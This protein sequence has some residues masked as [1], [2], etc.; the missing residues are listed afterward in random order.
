MSRTANWSC[1]LDDSGERGEEMQGGVRGSRGGGG[2]EAKLDYHNHQ[3]TP[4]A[5]GQ[6]TNPERWRL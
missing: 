2:H 1:H 3:L 4:D 5:I 6:P